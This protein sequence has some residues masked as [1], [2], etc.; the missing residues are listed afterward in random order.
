MKK[1]ILLGMINIWLSGCVTMDMA[2]R[3][4]DVDTKEG[5]PMIAMILKDGKGAELS[6]AETNEQGDFIIHKIKKGQYQLSYQKKGVVM[7][8]TKTIDLNTLSTK[9]ATTLSYEVTVEAAAGGKIIDSQT[10]EPVA[11]T[12]VRLIN[13][14]TEDTMA[15]DSKD[16]NAVDSQEDGRYGFEYIQPAKYK[17]QIERFDYLWI[18]TPAFV[19]AKGQTVIFDDIKLEKCPTEEDSVL[20]GES[21]YQVYEVTID[22]QAIIDNSVIR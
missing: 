17:I 18:E 15:V 6:S 16:I 21:K 14:G 13:L 19:I 9:G 7:P 5:V 22:G 10:N 2:G 11:Q 20:P 4:V 12:V 8:E 1:L 3:I